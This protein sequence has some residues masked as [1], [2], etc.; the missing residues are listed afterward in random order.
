MWEPEVL[1]FDNSKTEQ[2]VKGGLVYFCSQVFICIPKQ[3]EG[4]ERG[5]VEKIMA[6][7]FPQHLLLGPLFSI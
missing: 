6:F 7:R 5:S 1:K 2:S 3:N 4:E